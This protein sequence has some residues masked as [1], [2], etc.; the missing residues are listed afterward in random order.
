MNSPALPVQP[1][2]I[3]TPLMTWKAGQGGGGGFTDGIELEN[4]SGWILLEN[5]GNVQLES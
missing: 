1:N 4:A 2:S 3:P 5:G